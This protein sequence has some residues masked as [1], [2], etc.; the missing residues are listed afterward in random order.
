ML[1]RPGPFKDG[2]NDFVVHGD[3]AAV[4]SVGRGTKC[5]AYRQL[6]IE[7]GGHATMR[8]RFRPE[9]LSGAPFDDF[10]AVFATRIA[11]ADEFYSV[12]QHGIA[13]PDRRL[14]QRQAL[15]GMLWS[16][17][18]YHLD[19]TRWLTGDPTQ[20]APPHHRRGGRNS[21]WRH[22]H[23]ADVIAMPDKWE[24]PWYA[25]WDLAFH[26]VAFALIDPEFAKAQLVLLTRE[27]YMHPNGQLPAYE[28][29]FD[30]VNPPVH[31]WAALRVYEMDRDLHGV[32]DYA[33]LERVFHKLVLNFNWWVNRK[34]ATGRNVFQ[35]GFLGLDNIGIFDRS[36]QL[37]TGGYIN[38][39]DGTA[40]MAM[41]ALNLMRIALELAEAQPRL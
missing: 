14:V 39:S 30:D 17:Q 37:P 32:G 11:E 2:I 29:A 23:N 9:G 21:D 18:Y 27:W 34:D 31:A 5:A 40:W 15:A 3:R 41:Y 6:L 33:F 36:S 24:Y 4:S 19:V 7:A 22:L 35:G 12:L 10:D 25:A 28:W 1:D 16:K 38:Q 8:L 26:C 13:D 20:P